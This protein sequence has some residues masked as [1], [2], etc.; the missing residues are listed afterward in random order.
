VLFGMGI[1]GRRLSWRRTFTLSVATVCVLSSDGPGQVSNFGGAGLGFQ[2]QR[3]ARKLAGFV[4]AADVGPRH[5]LSRS[6]DKPCGG[7][8]RARGVAGGLRC[9]ETHIYREVGFGGRL[10]MRGIPTFALR[11]P[12]AEVQGGT[13]GFHSSEW[14]QERFTEASRNVCGGFVANMIHRAGYK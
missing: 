8:G 12:P 11:S 14:I 5:S 10:G 4:A 13:F 9:E 6:G 2:L 7:G 1:K 3:R